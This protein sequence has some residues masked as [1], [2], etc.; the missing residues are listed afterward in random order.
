MGLR[1]FIVKPSAHRCRSFVY[2]RGR[3]GAID[4]VAP[5]TQNPPRP[6]ASSRRYEHE[7]VLKTLIDDGTQQIVLS[8]CTHQAPSRCRWMA[9]LLAVDELAIELKNVPQAGVV[10]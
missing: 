1:G 6:A 7:Y 9:R 8:A 4:A 5:L 10:L 2:D 3:T